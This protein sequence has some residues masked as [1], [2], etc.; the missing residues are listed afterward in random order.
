[1]FTTY[2]VQYK[3]K[4]STGLGDTFVDSISL[5]KVK[6]AVHNS[7]QGPPACWTRLAQI[8]QPTH[9]LLGPSLVWARLL[10]TVVAK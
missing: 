2:Y 5:G 8:F 9:A 4:Q 6:K 10:N 7:L 1:M 3:A